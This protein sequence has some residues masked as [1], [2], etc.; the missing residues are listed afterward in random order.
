MNENNNIIGYDSQTGQPIYGSQNINMQQPIQTQINTGYTQQ[1]TQ[2]PKK[3][4]KGLAI[5]V[6]LVI[7]AVIVGIVLFGNQDKK[8]STNND[9]PNNP[10]VENNNNQN[11]K[12]QN[13]NS[14]GRVEEGTN[15]N[16]DENGAFLFSIED[17]FTITNRGTLVTGDVQRG[18]V[19]VGDIVQIIGL[20]KEILT[21]EVMEV[22][23]TRNKII[24]EA[25]V[26]DSIGIL[27]KDIAKDQ[28]QRGQVLA[29]PNSIK[30]AIKFDANVHILTKE[31]GGKQTP[32]F[33]GHRTQFYFDPA[34]VTGVI[35]FPDNVK[36]MNPNDD[37]SITVTLESSVAMEVGTKFSIREDG[38]MIGKGTV[39]KVY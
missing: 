28:V 10:K 15:T 7:I 29:K 17:V 14:T 34:D 30:A 12:Q 18:K 22:Q 26:G 25:T 20:S 9:T 33:N 3:S 24:D 38:R 4:K 2:P 36:M 27:L 13:N 21:T 35:D 11:N 8:G 19:K 23:L 39:T 37:G 6:V 32:I 5:V 31:E 1:P 16:Y